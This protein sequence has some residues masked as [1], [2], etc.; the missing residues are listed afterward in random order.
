MNQT[1][2]ITGATGYLGTRLSKIFLG[3]GYKIIALALNQMEQFAYK[4]EKNAKIYYLDKTPVR[5]IFDEN[6]IDIV[7][8]TATVYGRNKENIANM[9]KANVEFPCSVL[10]EAAKHDVKMFIN[11]DT[12]LVKNIN[13]YAMTKSHF[14]DW[15][16][17]FCDN[18]KCVNLKLDHFYGP[19]DK[20][21]K[22]IAWIIEQL[23]N[24]VEK[25]DLT[26]GSQTRDFIYIDDVLSAYKCVIDN[27]E[28]ILLGRTNT[29]EVGTGART[30]IKDIVISI[31][32]LLGNTKTVLNFGAIP[33]R[34][35][36]VL[37]YEVDT[38]G[39]RLLGWKPLVPVQEGL[40]KIIEIERL[41]K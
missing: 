36:E 41:N 16:S 33:Y 35:N 18:I 29:F 20:P 1:I 27:S 23:N 15:L 26:E 37:S 2:L 24:N 34:K 21:T 17:L 25:I 30:K 6:K 22:F 28:R 12:I 5:Q 38:S 32:H 9:I 31:K 13:P 4:N 19:N 8:H 14:A 39:L 40:K 11:T 10:E 3:Y 7:I